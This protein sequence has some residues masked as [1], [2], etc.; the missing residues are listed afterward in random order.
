MSTEKFIGV[1]AAI[2]HRPGGWCEYGEVNWRSGLNRM[3]HH[4]F[5]NLIYDFVSS[6]NALIL[7]QGKIDFF[8]LHVIIQ[9][10]W[11]LFFGDSAVP[12]IIPATIAWTFKEQLETTCEF[13]NNTKVENRAKTLEKEKNTATALQKFD[14]LR[15][16]VSA[17]E[18]MITEAAVGVEIEIQQQLDMHRG[19]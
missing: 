7:F 14:K 12:Q 16:D 2:Y 10:Y 15:N 13:K 5:F 1:L 11:P 17:F 6:D 19:K 3:V 4:F 8:V 18:E 9:S